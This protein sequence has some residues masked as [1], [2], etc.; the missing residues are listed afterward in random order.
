ME[1][2]LIALP[3]SALVG[4]LLGKNKGQG[5]G[6][7]PARVLEIATAFESFLR[8]FGTETYNP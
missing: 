8:A 5:A 1:I 3:I 4:Y 6:V 2:L 7:T